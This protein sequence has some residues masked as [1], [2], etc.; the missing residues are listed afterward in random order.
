MVNAMRRFTRLGIK[1]GM[2]NEEFME[3]GADFL[4]IQHTT[5]ELVQDLE[6][7]QNGLNMPSPPPPEEVHTY[8]GNESNNVTPIV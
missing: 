7:V 1:I 5:F 3:V 4:T 8:E 2:L 6:N